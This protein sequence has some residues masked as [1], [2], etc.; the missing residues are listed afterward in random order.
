M[1]ALARGNANIIRQAADRAG[2]TVK[3]TSLGTGQNY[4][5]QDLPQD[6]EIGPAPRIKPLLYGKSDFMRVVRQSDIV[7][8]IGEGDSFTDIY[9]AKR[10][11][12]LLGTKIAVMAAGRPLVIAPQTIG[13]FDN[14]LRRRTAA[15]VMKRATAVFSRDGLSTQFLHDNGITGNTDE[16]IDVAFALPFDPQP[17]SSDKVRVGLNVSG[18]LYNGGY[19]GKNE[20]GMA[21]DYAGL[22]HALI[23]RLLAM[24]GTEIHLISHVIGSGD[25]D[26]DHP[27]AE[28]LARR[29]P[30]LVLAPRFA[31]SE[32]AKSYISGMDYVVA[33][34]MHACIGAFS[35]GVPV[36]PVAY[37]RKF[38]GLFGTLGYRH[39][40]DGK[41]SSTDE[42]LNK[43]L[44][45][46][47]N[48]HQL[49]ADVRAGL[50]EAGRRLDRYRERV[51]AIL[52][53]LRRG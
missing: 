4:E 20:L 2:L 24:N 28:A 15:A 48:R 52:T 11:A 51:V 27:V 18:L 8:D 36:M 13:P 49:G 29:Y 40:V 22:T 30:A 41:A 47:D 32:R 12:F 33:G 10:F 53:G 14:A 6:V 5:A 1:D 31:T 39:M 21:L 9:G 19:T 17:K 42:A 45:D 43:I 26:D 50:A 7:F 35:A 3:F 16:F 44:D 46:F 37:S 25:A 34:R 23:E 38:N